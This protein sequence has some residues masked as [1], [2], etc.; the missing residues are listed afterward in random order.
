MVG[1]NLRGAKS[2][3]TGWY[4]RRALYNLTRVKKEN[5][6]DNSHAKLVHLIADP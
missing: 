3:I 1:L 6:L 2:G 4:I 5:R